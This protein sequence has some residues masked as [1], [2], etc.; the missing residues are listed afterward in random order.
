M[1]RDD[2][3]KPKP[4]AGLDAVVVVLNDAEREL[5]RK[6]AGRAPP[7]G[8]RDGN[9]VRDLHRQKLRRPD[10]PPEQARHGIRPNAKGY[11]PNWTRD[12]NGLPKEDPCPVE[13]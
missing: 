7:R 10:P 13:P 2:D 8:E 3:N 9:E 5:H 11:P 6:K 12:K 1:P 4:P